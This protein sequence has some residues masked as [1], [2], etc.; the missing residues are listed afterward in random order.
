MIKQIKNLIQLS[1]GTEKLLLSLTAPIPD[2]VLIYSLDSGLFKL[3]NGSSTYTDLEALF[4]YEQLSSF[5]D[6][7][8]TSLSAIFE[9]V[10]IADD[11]KVIIIK[12]DEVTETYK[13]GIS[14]ILITD[15]VNDLSSIN[16]LNTEIN[17]VINNYYDLLVQVSNDINADNN[18]KFVIVSN[19]EY[20]NSA[21]SADDLSSIPS[22]SAEIDTSIHIRDS[23]FYYDSGLTKVVDKLLLED[24]KT[25]YVKLDI[26]CND[27]DVEFE[28]NLIVSNSK[29]TAT[30]I[31]N[32]IF[33]ITL[34][35][36]CDDRYKCAFVLTIDINSTTY[37]TIKCGASKSLF[38]LNELYSAYQDIPVVIAI[39]CDSDRTY[40]LV[41]DNTSGVYGAVGIIIFDSILNHVATK[42]YRLIDSGASGT[43]GS[44]S[45][46]CDSVGN[47]YIAI[48]STI[49]VDDLASC[50][51]KFDSELNLIDNEFV[52]LTNTSLT[53]TSV[54]MNIIDDIV[55]FRVVY[56]ESVASAITSKLIYLDTNLTILTT[57]TYNGL[58]V[59]VI[60]D[61]DNYILIIRQSDFTNTIN[62][63]DKV[64]RV[65]QSVYITSASFVIRCFAVTD[66]GYICHMINY[67]DN[68]PVVIILNKNMVIVSQKYIDFTGKTISV[69]TNYGYSFTSND[70]LYL[71]NKYTSTKTDGTATVTI[72]STM[73]TMIDEN[74]NI[75]SKILNEDHV[76]D[77]V[78]YMRCTNNNE[79][80]FMA[81]YLNKALIGTYRNNAFQLLQKLALEDIY[82]SYVL[83]SG[84]YDLI[85]EDT[86]N[87]TLTASTI[88]ISITT[89]ETYYELSTYDELSEVVGLLALFDEYTNIS[90]NNKR[91]IIEL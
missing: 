70:K 14:D 7:K 23:I 1:R 12:Y 78:T 6:D 29:V 21:A 26:F 4:S 79:V 39:T 19:G 87:Y 82:G 11:G 33:S 25:Y 32:T 3:G 66:T 50:I 40:C 62:F 60:D 75:S 88:T 69:D 76:V 22:G 48:L 64:T 52:K 56:N 85:I 35:G 67:T 15:I 27:E 5:I 10:S 13:Y 54:N 58:I 2:G 84:E 68:R 89:D 38:I 74:F 8:T 57:K 86:V 61:G 30:K 81:M 51:I 91:T 34:D 36:L 49:N 55:I 63:I 73:I 31:S 90:L 53:I 43:T 41:V 24:N 71:I 65:T 46:K 18:G 9:D 72:Y 83:N 37:K 16:S 28:S 80:I 17:N 45:I 20:S 42:W 47:I 44:G 59:N 77:T